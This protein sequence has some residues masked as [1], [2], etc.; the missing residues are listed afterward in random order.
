M[1]TLMPPWRLHSIYFVQICLFRFYDHLILSV[2]CLTWRFLSIVPTFCPLP[3]NDCCFHCYNIFLNEKSTFS[4]IMHIAYRARE[5]EGKKLHS[6]VQYKL[7][8]LPRYMAR[9]NVDSVGLHP[10]SVILTFFFLS[11]V[12]RFSHCFSNDFRKMKSV[13]P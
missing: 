6:W 5:E 11:L 3:L 10:L 12:L 7:I 13:L 2:A 4:L 9:M 1:C 8:H